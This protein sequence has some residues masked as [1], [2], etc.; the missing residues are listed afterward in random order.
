VRQK[1]NTH[2]TPSF[3]KNHH[4]YL[5]PTPLSLS[6]DVILEIGAGKGDF[7]CQYAKDH[8][9]KTFI[10]VE[11]NRHVCYYIALKKQAQSLDNLIIILDDASKLDVYLPKYSIQTL[12]LQFSDPWP[13]AKHHKRRLTYPTKLDLY[14]KLLKKDGTLLFK[15]DH[16]KLYIESSFYIQNKFKDC[17]FDDDAQAGAY[18]TE[19]ERKK[20][21]LGPIYQIQAGGYDETL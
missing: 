9:E 8:P 10:A 7:I 11:M 20:R 12:Y 5:E 6:G 21:P 14:G 16:Q 18:M 13:K 17:I 4:V 19:Y 2:A 15:T 1:F 3:F